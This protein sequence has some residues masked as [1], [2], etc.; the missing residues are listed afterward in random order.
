MLPLFGMLGVGFGVIASVM[1]FLITY[2]EYVH[3]YAET[4]TPRRIALQ[5]AVV[6][7]AFFVLASVVVGYILTLLVTW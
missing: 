1:A 7:F 5:A 4:R 3:H 2:G 6:T